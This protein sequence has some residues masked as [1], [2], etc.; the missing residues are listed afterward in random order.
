MAI[1]ARARPYF[2]LGRSRF[3]RRGSAA[4]G[5]PLVVEAEQ[6]DYVLHIGVRVNP[7]T[8]PTGVGENVVWLRSSR[9]DELVSRRFGEGEVGQVVAVDMA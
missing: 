4:T 2:H 6:S 9:G 7:T 3:R 8:H 1:L 5:H